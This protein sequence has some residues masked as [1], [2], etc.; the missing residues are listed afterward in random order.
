M[1]MIE[2]VSFR[3]MSLGNPVEFENCA[4]WSEK[5]NNHRIPRSVMQ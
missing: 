4:Q 3:H 1:D 5:M 2:G